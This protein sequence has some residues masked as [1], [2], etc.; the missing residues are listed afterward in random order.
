MGGRNGR[1]VMLELRML[2]SKLLL[3]NGWCVGGRSGSAGDGG[4]QGRD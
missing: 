3:E 1:A 4:I 2:G